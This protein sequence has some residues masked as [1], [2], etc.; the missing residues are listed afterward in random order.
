MARRRN[1]ARRPHL[2]RRLPSN[3]IPER[4]VRELEAPGP[5]PGAAFVAWLWPPEQLKGR[6]Q[7]ALMAVLQRHHDVDV[8]VGGLE[9]VLRRFHAERFLRH[10]LRDLLKFI[11]SLEPGDALRMGRWFMARLHEAA[12]A[13]PASGDLEQ[14]DEVLE[15]W[16]NKLSD[17]DPEVA[18][19]CLEVA[20]AVLP[21]REDLR[22]ARL[23]MFGR[24]SAAPRGPKRDSLAGKLVIW[25]LAQAGVAAREIGGLMRSEIPAARKTAQR[26]RHQTLDGLLFDLFGPPKTR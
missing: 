21:F 26:L 12:S 13:A 22:R 5:H 16:A 18:V 1:I 9:D 3:A 4:V 23:R 17:V 24:A 6:A 15:F 11:A 14:W 10:G 8:A 25:A 7:A 2:V 20:S 19:T